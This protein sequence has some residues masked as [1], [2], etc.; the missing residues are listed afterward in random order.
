LEIGSEVAAAFYFNISLAYLLGVIERMRMQEA[1]DAMARN[2]FDRKLEVSVLQRGVMTGFINAFSKRRMLFDRDAFG[3]DDAFRG[4]A[5]A[6]R[7]YCIFKWVGEG[8]DKPYFQRGIDEGG[9]QN[10]SYVG[11]ELV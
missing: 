4:I 2:A 6:R 10:R 5:G 11:S 9:I 1:P 8:I 7:C 3:G